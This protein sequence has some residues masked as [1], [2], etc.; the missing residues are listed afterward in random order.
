MLTLFAIPKPFRG[1]IGVIQ[2][3]AIRSWTLLRPRCEIILFGDDAGVAVAAAELGVRHVPAI[4]RNAYGTPLVSDVFAQAERVATH[5]L[6]CYINADIIVTGDFLPA[7][8][9]IHRRPFLM[10]GQRWDLDLTAPWAFDD[11]GWEAKLAAEVRAR[12]VL[13]PHTGVDYYVFP[14]GLWG[15]IPPFAVGRVVYDNWLIWRARSSGVPVVD[16]TRAVTCIHQNH[17]RTYASLGVAPPDAADDFQ[18]GV[19]A[20]RNLELAGGRRH[21]FTLRNANWVLTRRWLVPALT[22][23]YLWARFKS[24][25]RLLVPRGA[26][27]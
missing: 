18:T 7:V 4:A 11:P 26:S 21:V 10:L 24:R 13:H 25:M 16:A 19:E 14:T 22:P 3:N 6:L 1:H 20:R 9:R 5:D 23:W 2:R 27:S 8:S 12:G 17:D 15:A